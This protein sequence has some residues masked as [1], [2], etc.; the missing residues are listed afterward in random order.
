MYL[1]LSTYNKVDVFDEDDFTI[2][3]VSFEK[4][5]DI[6]KTG[7]RFENVPNLIYVPGVSYKFVRRLKNLRGGYVSNQKVLVLSSFKFSLFLQNTG[8]F[9]FNNL[10][11]IVK[12]ATYASLDV[13]VWYNGFYFSLKTDEYDPYLWLYTGDTRHIIETCKTGLVRSM[14]LYRSKFMIALDSIK[15][16]M[17]FDPDSG[18]LRVGSEY[19]YEIDTCTSSEFKRRILL[20]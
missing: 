17:F 15:D 14:G 10:I 13:T 18:Y 20:G 5:P 9:S 4:F 19:S 2:E 8:Y 16:I 1:C 7:I 11:V 6:L 3:R 12:S